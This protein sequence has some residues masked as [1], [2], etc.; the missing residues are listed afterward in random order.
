MVVIYMDLG[1]H[2][3]QPLPLKQDLSM[4]WDEDGC[5]D[6]THVDRPFY[7]AKPGELVWRP[8]PAR[9]VVV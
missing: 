9:S 1:N 6:L 3:K 4:K 7:L 5:G 8:G 2:S